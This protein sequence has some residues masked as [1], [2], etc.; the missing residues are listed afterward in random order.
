MT[1]EGSVTNT[2]QIMAMLKASHISRAMGIVYCRSHQMYDY[3]VSKGNNHA[4]EAARAMALRLI[5]PTSGYSYTTIHISL[6][7]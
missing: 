2:N 4:D 6:T 1:K 7:P 5:S 3:I